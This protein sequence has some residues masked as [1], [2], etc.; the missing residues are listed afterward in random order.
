MARG[1]QE[2]GQQGQRAGAG[3]ASTLCLVVPPAS[4]ALTR[5]LGRDALRGQPPGQDLGAAKVIHPLGCILSKA[6]LEG[7]GAGGSM[8]AQQ[9]LILI[10]LYLCI[11]DTAAAAAAAGSGRCR[12]GGVQLLQ[13][14]LGV[15]SVAAQHLEG[16]APK[17]EARK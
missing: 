15:C 11:S 17:H 2:A 10:C 3:H 9:R 14:F 6:W 8:L 1:G 12:L 16:Q 7:S 4:L 13:H 5:V